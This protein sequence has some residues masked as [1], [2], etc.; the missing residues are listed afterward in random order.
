M[1]DIGAL[2]R[3]WDVDERGVRE[4]MHRAA[5][6][7]ERERWHALWL[8]SRGWSEA[9]VGGIGARPPY[10]WGMAEYVCDG[11]TVGDGL[12]ADGWSPPPS[13][14]RLKLR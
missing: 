11:W 13:T 10:D 9:R 8:L 5:T 12:R 3:Q 7:R 2:L 14:K 4:R 6:P 1:K